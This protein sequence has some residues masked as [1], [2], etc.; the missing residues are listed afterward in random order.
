MTSVSKQAESLEVVH[1]HTVRRPDLGTAAGAHPQWTGEESDDD[2]DEDVGYPSI[3]SS[4]ANN[5]LF[6]G[7]D[8]MA[9]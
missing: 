8:L 9:K 7:N 2:D 3:S 5:R 4:S 6:N 1:S